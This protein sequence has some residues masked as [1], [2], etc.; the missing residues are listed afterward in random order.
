MRDSLRAGAEL[1][2]DLFLGGESSLVMLGED[3]LVAERDVED[4]SA[5]ADD[6]RIDIELLL[7]L[8]RQT[9]GS[10][11]EVSN[12]AVFDRDLHNCS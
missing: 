10:G 7:D 11:Q 3:F 8:G 2:E 6:R 4:P 1:F 5:A 12:A 9:G